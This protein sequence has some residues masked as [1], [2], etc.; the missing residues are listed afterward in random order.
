[1][2]LFSLPEPP[3]PGVQYSPERWNALPEAGM[4]GRSR[5]TAFTLLEL[6]VV[7]AIIALLVA[8]L[9]PSLS[10]TREEGKK[11]KCLANLHNI[12]QA[13]HQYAMEDRTELLIPIH[14]SMLESCPYWEWRTVN[15]FAWGGR[16]GQK[17]FRTGPSSSI[18]L[19][20]Q[21]P[22]ARPQYDATRRPLTRYMLGTVERADSERLELFHCPSDRGYPL[23]PD[24]DDAPLA[25]AEQ[26][27]YDTLGNSYR[28]SLAMITLITGDDSSA[29]HFST[30]VW[31]HRLGTLRSVSM[32]AVVGEPTF[33]NMIG[34]DSGP[35]PDPVL[36]TGWHKKFMVDNL[37]F[38]DGSVRAQRATG[39]YEFAPDVGGTPVYH[40]G[41]FSRGTGWQ[42][43]DYPVSGARLWGSNEL[44]RDAYG[45]DYDTKWPFA[46]RQE[47]MAGH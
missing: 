9:L 38:C 2:G 47:N 15:W 10:L 17:P 4:L 3:A 41:L 25:N 34:R 22:D 39:R 16:S 8:T 20:A 33:F 44:W 35:D 26:P 31:G 6:L 24:I 32:L 30:G 28:A 12:G 14:E 13:L 46:D 36:V 11:A 18:M 43:D 19:S 21:G 45:P 37:L 5:S 27:C 40:P 1:L 23:H 29:G 42:I 7:V